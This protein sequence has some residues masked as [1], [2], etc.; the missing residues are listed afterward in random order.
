MRETESGFYHYSNLTPLGPEERL[1]C[2]LARSHYIGTANTA[3]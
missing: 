1:Q 3:I 2:A